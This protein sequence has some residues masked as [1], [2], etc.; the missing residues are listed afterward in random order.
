MKSKRQ[1]K[2][3][4]NKGFFSSCLKMSETLHSESSDEG[5]KEVKIVEELKSSKNGKTIKGEEN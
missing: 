1:R 2:A 4:K 3:G 5:E